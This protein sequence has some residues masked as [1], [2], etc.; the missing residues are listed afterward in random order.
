MSKTDFKNELELQ[1]LIAADPTI[2]PANAC[3]S[4]EPRRWLL[5]Q[6]EA[7]IPSPADTTSLWAVDFLLLDQDAMPTLVEVK[8]ATP[9]KTARRQCLGQ[10]LD[11][12][13]GARAA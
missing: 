12:L 11:Y 1:D 3:R 4:P 7:R 10:M 8:L 6:R 2:I 9:G 13:T 5:V